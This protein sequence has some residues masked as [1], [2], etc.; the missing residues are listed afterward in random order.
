MMIRQWAAGF[1]ALAVMVLYIRFPPVAAR[2]NGPQANDSGWMLAWSDRVSTGRM[3]VPFDASK[4]IWK[5]AANGW[6]KS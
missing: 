3:E 1:D 2:A 6:G 5:A 4:W